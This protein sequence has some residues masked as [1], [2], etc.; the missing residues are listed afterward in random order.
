MI[1]LTSELIEQ[2]RTP[3]GGFNQRTM[4]QL[5]VWPLVAGWKERLVGK[6]VGDRRW[7]SALA[8][9]KRETHRYRGNTRRRH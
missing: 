9:S 6:K 5:G 7:R 8:A 3:K 2:L 4:E 1:V